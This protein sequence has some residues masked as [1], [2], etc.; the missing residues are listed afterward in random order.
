MGLLGAVNVYAEEV[1]SGLQG[2]IH[3]GSTSL[4][5]GVESIFYTEDKNNPAAFGLQT[6]T[7][8]K[9]AAKLIGN[10]C[11]KEGSRHVELGR[12]S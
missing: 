6:S 10:A 5:A 9:L 11:K 1:R 4:A 2:G 7:E 3:V 12:R 8:L